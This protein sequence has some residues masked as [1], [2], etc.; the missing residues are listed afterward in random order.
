MRDHKRTQLLAS[1][2]VA[3][4]AA[5]AD[6]AEWKKHVVY[7]GQHCNTAV[8]ADFSGMGNRT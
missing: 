4:S 8:A 5:C 7:S 1:I 3:L 6:G 2:A